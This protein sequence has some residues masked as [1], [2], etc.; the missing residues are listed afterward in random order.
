MAKVRNTLPMTINW[1]GPPRREYFLNE[2]VKRNNWTIGVEVGVRV[3]RT[4]FYLLEE[5][6]HLKMYA[7][8]IDISQFYSSEVQKRYGDRLVVLSG[9]SAEQASNIK[10]QVDFVFIDASHSTKGVVKD[11]NAYSPL[12]MH[13]N[14]LT[15]HDIDFP[16]VQEAL[17][18]CN[19]DYNVGP[20]NVWQQKD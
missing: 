9:D 13:K 20:D 1:S 16:A 8:D 15:G 3:G 11:I 19:I 5:N 7:V 2:E 12:L 10:E 17:K 14:G 18:I 4:L 6:P